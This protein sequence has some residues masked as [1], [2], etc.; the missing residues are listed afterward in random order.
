MFADCLEDRFEHCSRF[1]KI[2]DHHARQLIGPSTHRLGLIGFGLAS[3]FVL[4]G[5]AK[6]QW[7]STINYAPG[8]PMLSASGN[9]TSSASGYGTM[10]PG[11]PAQ[12]GVKATET[13][14]GSPATTSASGTTRD[15]VTYQWLGT[16][17]VPQ[18]SPTFNVSAS[19]TLAT[20]TDLNS[21]RA[22]SDAFTDAFNLGAAAR[23]YPARGDKAPYP[24]HSQSTASA[25]YTFPNAFTQTFTVEAS[26]GGDGSATSTATCLFNQ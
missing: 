11:L 12:S 8:F 13:S 2:G 23:T 14:S 9:G 3:L 22:L 24:L 20:P 26:T 15:T 17:P 18:L 6:A 19:A 21:G 10:T 16:G 4:A 5:P 25:S 1:G 7:S